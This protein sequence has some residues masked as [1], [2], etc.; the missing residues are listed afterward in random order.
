MKKMLLHSC[1]GPCS[2]V[3]I[4]RLKDDYDLTIFYCNPNIEPLEEYE[5]RKVEQQ[6]VCSIMAVP[7][8]DFDYDNAGWRKFVEGLENEKEGE[9]RCTKCFQF[10]LLKTAEFAKKNGFEIFASTLSVSPHKN[11]N[12]I[13]EV[14]NEIS[15][16]FEIEFLPES[17]KKKDGYLRS[18]NLSKEFDLYRQN[19]CGCLFSK[20]SED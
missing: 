2:T 5:K 13:N 7:F 4:E 6:K 11:T 3:V 18:I 20:R 17:F 12:V 9:A 15:K 8:L 19:Y 1:C 16:K 14:G 10:R